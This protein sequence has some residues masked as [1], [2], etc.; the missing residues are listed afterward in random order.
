[1]IKSALFL[2]ITVFATT[3]SRAADVPILKADHKEDV[4]Q[5]LIKVEH[6]WNE[7][8]KDRDKAALSA[9]CSE[10]FLFTGD[11]GKLVDRR[12]YIGDA[13][14]LVKVS[15]Y[16][17]TDVTARS[18]GDTGVVNGQWSG[19]VEVDGHSAEITLRFTDTFV[20]RENRWWAVASHMTRV[21]EAGAEK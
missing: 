13:A 6:V 1:M 19:T 8:F 7:A 10:D 16:T 11:D 21:S 20:R 18:Y 5:Q 3:L 17:M 15:K 2:L 14:T 12:R 9:L 4:E